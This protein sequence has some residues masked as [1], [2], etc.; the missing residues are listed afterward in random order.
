MVLTSSGCKCV[1]VLQSRPTGCLLFAPVLPPA[2]RRNVSSSIQHRAALPG[3]HMVSR[4]RQSASRFL[5]F[6]STHTHASTPPHT[7]TRADVSSF[8]SDL[9]FDSAP[10][11]C[12]DLDR[13][14]GVSSDHP[15]GRQR[16]G[17]GAIRSSDPLLQ[18]RFL[19]GRLC[20][21]LT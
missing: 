4:C 19:L 18:L 6:F 7:K 14:A 1:L 8:P 21:S 16:S 3:L 5:V 11:I 15:P 17:S 20:T 13:V 12:A 10:V 2:E 9:P